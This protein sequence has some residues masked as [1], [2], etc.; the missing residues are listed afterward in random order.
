MEVESA[1]AAEFVRHLLALLKPVTPMK[2]SEWNEKYRFAPTF[3]PRP[4]RWK[5]DPF[6]VQIL[7]TILDESVSSLTLMFCSQF[8]GKTSIVESVL[9][10]MIEQ[11]PCASVAV[12]PSLDN[13]LIWSKNRFSRLID[14]TPVLAAL[15]AKRNEASKTGSGKNTIVHKL[16]PGGFFVAGGS[17]S[18]SQLAAHT[19]RLTF[20]DEV[21][22][23]PVIVGKEDHEEGDPI[24][25]VEQRASRFL[26]PFS[27]KTSTPTVRGFSRIE[28]EFE[29]SDKRR[30]YVKCPGCKKEFVILWSHIKWERTVDE[31]GNV[32]E[33]KPET[34]YLECPVCQR[35]IS[36]AERARIVRAGRW[37]A[38]NPKVKN[39]RGYHANAFLVLGPSKEGFRSWLH[40]FAQRYLDE[41]ELGTK[42]MRE[43]QNLVL[44]ETFELETDPPPDFLAL[45]AR[46]ER[47]AEFEGEV[48]VPER[49]ILL[50]MGIDVQRTRIE[51]EVAGFGLQDESWGVH[52]GVVTGNVQS[53]KFWDEEVK[54]LIDKKWRHASGHWLSPFCTFIDTGDKPHQMYNFVRRC[55]T[56]VYASKGFAGFVPN[57]VVRSGGS[58][59]KLFIIKVDTPKES[60][61]SNLRLAEPGPG[62]CHFP[63]NEK[64]GY[65]EVYFSQLTAERMTLEGAYPHF[66]KHHSSVRNEALDIRVLALAAKEVVTEDSNYTKARVW[67]ASKPENDW[68]PKEAGRVPEP[69]LV[70]PVP[71]D[72]GVQLTPG[73]APA[74]T[75]PPRISPFRPP[76]TG[77]SRVK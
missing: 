77:W 56:H 51:Y 26:N 14:D 38:T 62:Y 72:N 23:Y 52:Y 58:F 21:D 66:V 67:L 54:P 32:I 1:E 45:H 57:W 65:D 11:A 15:V 69:H 48:V 9:G 37:V 6:Q 76:K 17:N 39:R 49:V 27:I 43:W 24:L 41:K 55:T 36:D 47:Y 59:A 35:R 2:P 68:R 13:A 22:R 16:F 75:A 70:I 61:Y 40:Y 33:E 12:F 20:F 18:T 44:G 60:L 29:R 8:L 74:V 50:T 64:A 19:A 4:G 42:G 71:S 30:W 53:P 34:A 63:L 46:R 7:D 31:K 25:L 5:N 3:S 73:L 28:K 10:W